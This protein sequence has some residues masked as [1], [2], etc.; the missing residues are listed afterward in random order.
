MQ[1]EKHIQISIDGMKDQYNFWMDCYRHDVKFM[2]EGSEY[3]QRSLGRA[4][5]YKGALNMF[6]EE[7]E[8]SK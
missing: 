1:Q 2:G 6:G 8:E 4:E 5:G 7:V 3:A